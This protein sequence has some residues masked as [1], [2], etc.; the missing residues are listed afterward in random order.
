MQELNAICT[1]M[2]LFF[3]FPFPHLHTIASRNLFDENPPNQAIMKILFFSDLHGDQITI[4]QI[5]KQLSKVDYGFGLGDYVTF[6]SELAKTLDT[7]NVGTEIYFLP[8]NHDDVNELK[9]ICQEY[10]GFHFFHSRYVKIK[11]LTFAGLGGGIPGLPFAVSEEEARQILKRF[12]NL[13]NL[14]LCTHTPPHGTLVDL[15]GS[16]NHIGY[17]SLRDFITEIQPKVVYSGHVHEAEGKTDL[18]GSTKL[19]AVGNRGLV[20]T[21]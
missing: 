9:W 5:K 18:I 13:E 14:V 12:V 21:I 4:S 16:G 1:K 17:Q 11:Q 10:D 7:L 2:V 6:G 8:G 3:L 20:I 15:T 19:V